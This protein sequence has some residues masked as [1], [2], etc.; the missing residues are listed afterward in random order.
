[1]H[2]FFFGKTDANCDVYLH[3]ENLTCHMKLETYVLCKV[4]QPRE[5][6]A[7]PYGPPTLGRKNR[8]DHLLRSSAEFELIC[9]T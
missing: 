4:L 1:M 8:L 2:V 5:I 6:G 7:P 3:L 9:E